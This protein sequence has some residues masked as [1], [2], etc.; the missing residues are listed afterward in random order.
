MWW[1]GFTESSVLEGL[2][3]VVLAAVEWVKGISVEDTRA[4]HSCRFFHYHCS[5]FQDHFILVLD[6][7]DWK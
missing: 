7:I 4:I 5:V 3:D 6:W 2:M 1:V